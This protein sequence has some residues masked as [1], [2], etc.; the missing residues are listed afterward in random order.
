MKKIILVFAAALIGTVG[1]NKNDN[2][3]N[4][5]MPALMSREEKTGTQVTLT[6]Y[7]Y[8]EYGQTTGE[9][10]KVNGVVVYEESEYEWDAA[11]YEM[12]SLRTYYTG[13]GIPTAT[14]KR[15]QTYSK[16]Y[17]VLVKRE[18]FLMGAGGSETEPIE[19]WEQTLSGERVSRLE[20][21]EDGVRTVQ[22]P[23]VYDGT[24]V[25]YDKVVTYEDGTEETFKVSEA[26]YAGGYNRTTKKGEDIV[27]Y[28]VY[29]QG[30]VLQYEIYKDGDAQNGTLVEKLSNVRTS[31]T[32]EQIIRMYDITHYDEEGKNPVVTTV[33]E[34]IVWMVVL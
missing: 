3:G 7:T 6:E 26:H 33:K 24:Q 16:Q 5:V 10:Q 21:L 28:G 19:L 15:V 14:H 8:D 2:N 12:T 25:N 23:Y 11:A 9:T 22:G 31:T 20:T 4:G 32:N 17:N 1:C 29:V 30:E 34:T 18:V 13:S 27:E